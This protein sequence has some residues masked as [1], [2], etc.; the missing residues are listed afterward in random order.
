M[1]SATC[2]FDKPIRSVNQSGRR[3]P[4]SV[5]AKSVHTFSTGCTVYNLY[6]S[7]NDAGRASIQTRVALK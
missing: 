1:N 7:G 4:I 3:I 2:K 5:S 6:T